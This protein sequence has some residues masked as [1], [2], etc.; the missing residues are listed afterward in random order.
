M[1]HLHWTY[2]KPFYFVYNQSIIH[3]KRKCR[4][5]TLSISNALFLCG[6]E[7]AAV[8]GTIGTVR[9]DATTRHQYRYMQLYWNICLSHQ[10]HEYQAISFLLDWLLVISTIHGISLWYHNIIQVNAITIWPKISI[11]LLFE[12]ITQNEIRNSLQWH[13]NIVWL[14]HRQ[15]FVIA[16]LCAPLPLYHYRL[17]A[18]LMPSDM[19]YVD[20][21][22]NCFSEVS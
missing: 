16:L 22:D 8:A 17:P 10:Y 9:W 13:R 7:F 6:L 2:S 15:N 19:V 4:E 3:V 12:E 18:L 5:E 20:Q 14:I 1:C 11:Q 21:T